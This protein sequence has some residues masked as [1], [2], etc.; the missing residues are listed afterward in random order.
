MHL[1]IEPTRV[2]QSAG[3]D[4]GDS[5]H[6]GRVCKDWRPALRTKVPINCLTAIAGVVECLELSLNRHCWFGNSDKDREGS[7][8]L[9]LTVRAVAHAEENRICIRRIPNLAAEATTGQFRH[10][11][12]PSIVSIGVDSSEKV[13]GLFCSAVTQGIEQFDDALSIFESALSD[14]GS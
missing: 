8:S 3:F 14:L 7:S 10:F 4:K 5:W 9:A 6:D 2:I 13:S 12:P 11:H 1:G